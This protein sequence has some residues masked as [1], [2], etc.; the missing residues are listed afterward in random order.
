MKFEKNYRMGSLAMWYDGGGWLWKVWLHSITWWTWR[1]CFPST[2]QW[3]MGTDKAGKEMTCNSMDESWGA[4]QLFY[5]DNA[6]EELHVTC[7]LI[8]LPLKRSALTAMSCSPATPLPMVASNMIHRCPWQ[9]LP[10]HCTSQSQMQTP[11]IFFA[12]IS[13]ELVDGTQCTYVHVFLS[14]SSTADGCFVIYRWPWRGLPVHY[15][16]QSQDADSS[17]CELVDGTRTRWVYV[18]VVLSCNFTTRSWLPYDLKMIATKA[19]SSL[20]KSKSDARESLPVLMLVSLSMARS[21][22]LTSVS[23]SP[24]TPQLMTSS[25]SMDDHDKDCRFNA[26]VKVRCWARWCTCPCCALLQLH[27]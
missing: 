11:W 27:R 15:K 4:V 8:L 12:L 25:W 5:M 13:C 19:T 22:V 14:C 21:T 18:H 17:S 10:F 3:K 6:W 24:A 20:Q 16:S 26:A 23:F 9:G 1:F 2:F 7:S